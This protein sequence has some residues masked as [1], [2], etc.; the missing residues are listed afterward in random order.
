MARERLSEL[1][2][3]F[4]ERADIDERFASGGA[5]SADD[6]D[7]IQLTGITVPDEPGQAAPEGHDGEPVDPQ[8]PVSFYEAGVGD[9]DTAMQPRSMAETPAHDEEI[10]VQVPETL[11]RPIAR[12]NR[13]AEDLRAII[14]DLA[15]E[16]SEPPDDGTPERTTKMV[17]SVSTPDTVESAAAGSDDSSGHAPNIS[18]TPDQPSRSIQVL[19]V[20]KS[21]QSANDLPSDDA[22]LPE[23]WDADSLQREL[24]AR[25]RHVATTRQTLF[26]RAAT[27]HTADNDEDEAEEDTEAYRRTSTI[28]RRRGRRRRK[29]LR[30]RIVRYTFWLLVA[31]AAGLGMWQAW[32]FVR[33]QTTTAP[34]AYAEAWRLLEH[35]Q[36]IE[37]SQAFEQIA[38][39]FPDSP[40]RRDAEFM[41]ALA[42][43]RV[44]ASARDAAQQAYQR[45]AVLFENFIAASP[46]DA[47][48]ARAQSL[49]GLMYFKMDRY[50]DAVRILRDPERRLL[51]PAG[52]L[53]SLR[54]LARAHAALEDYDNA[55]SAYLMAASLEDNVTPDQDYLELADLYRRLADN[56]ARPEDRQAYQ[57][58]AVEQWERALRIPSLPDGLKR[59]IE[60]LRTVAVTQLGNV[61]T[62]ETEAGTETNPEN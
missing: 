51:D 47:K 2:T 23:F 5:K 44:P 13:S 50:G 7:F 38:R 35:G 20:E 62:P 52:Y 34:V 18:T 33:V 53:P 55:A 60:N 49:L 15:D 1:E 46:R 28:A 30:R 56:A 32:L 45:A 17:E 40:E 12:T 4:L 31:G 36:F 14:R 48:Q 19:A 22:E 24:E 41:A 9:V 10:I 26:P 57:R 59:R 37:A 42:L 6:L 3:A 61:A 54:V 16:T 43:S 8:G 29:S 11:S 21:P 58:R 25:E 39:R 27:N